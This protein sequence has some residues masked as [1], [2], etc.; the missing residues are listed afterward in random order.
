MAILIRL[1]AIILIIGII[2]FVIK[3][4]A[5]KET[6]DKIDDFKQRNEIHQLKEKLNEEKNDHQEEVEYLNSTINKL[7]AEL[8]EVKSNNGTID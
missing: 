2:Y 7:K 4:A 8:E 6:E 5:N 3:N 1:L